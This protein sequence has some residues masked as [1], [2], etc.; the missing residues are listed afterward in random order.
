L[1]AIKD[2]SRVYDV[3]ITAAGTKLIPKGGVSQQAQPAAIQTA[4]TTPVE[5]PTL[6][7]LP[8]LNVSP[9][10]LKMGVMLVAV[11]MVLSILR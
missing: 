2:V 5:T 11:L 7:T 3:N 4:N 1:L 10:Q 6:P 8:A 9:E